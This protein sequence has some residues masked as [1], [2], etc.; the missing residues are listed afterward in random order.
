MNWNSSW[1][2]TRGGPKAGNFGRVVLL[3]VVVA[4]LLHA[5]AIY[6][7]GRIPFVADITEVIEWR[8]RSFNV[9]QVEF[10]PE[11]V[12]EEVVSEAKDSAPPEDS[13]SLM[14][15]VEELLPLLDNLEVDVSPEILEPEVSLKLEDPALIGE[16][17]GDLL[18]PVQA[19]EVS[20]DLVELGSSEIIFTEVPEG[21][22]VIEEGAVSADVPD[23]DEYLRDAVRKGAGGLS[24]EGTLEG[25][26]SLGDLLSLPKGELNESKAALPSDL[27]SVSYTHLTL[28][29]IYS[30]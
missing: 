23:P 9:E 30:V 27:L 29:T 12:V 15:E 16:E 10:L 25:Y 8:S 17:S 19:P 21:Q 14:M 11:S 3:A 22:V 7:L 18:E 2:D 5:L 20:A 26:S 13:A 24:E 28:P 4:I 6:V 1:D